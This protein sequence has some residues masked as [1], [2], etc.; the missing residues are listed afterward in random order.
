MLSIKR[1]TNN[2][3]ANKNLYNFQHKLQNKYNYK[4]INKII[5]QFHSINKNLY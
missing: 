4:I 1:N 2:R 3:K 5:N